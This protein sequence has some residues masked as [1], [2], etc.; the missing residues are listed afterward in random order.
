MGD[1]TG[2]NI[3]PTTSELSPSQGVVNG[4]ATYWLGD[5]RR[6]DLTLKRRQGAAV[7]I[8]VTREVEVHSP[9]GCY[10]VA[11]IELQLLDTS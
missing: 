6:R 4:E 2:K 5:T 10:A 3:A 9:S 8:L 1:P 7:A 11:R